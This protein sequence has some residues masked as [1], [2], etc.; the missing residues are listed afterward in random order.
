MEIEINIKK[1]HLYYLTGLTGLISLIIIELVIGYGWSS[2]M[3]YHEIL[4][5]DR[6][7]GKSGTTITLDDSLVEVTGDLIVKEKTTIKGD[8][9]VKGDFDMGIGEIGSYPTGWGYQLDIATNHMEYRDWKFCFLTGISLKELS[10]AEM[11]EYYCRITGTWGGRW[12]IEAIGDYDLLPFTNTLDAYIRC[13]ATC[14][15]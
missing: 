14:V 9:L 3:P 6:I 8:L 2:E 15:S 4:Y 13:Q 11:G 5:T 1:K 10:D 12:K 7:T